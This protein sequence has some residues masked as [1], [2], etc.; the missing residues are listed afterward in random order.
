MLYRLIILNGERRGERITATQAP[1]TIGRGEACEIRFS[2]PEIA[3]AHAELTHRSEGL[4]IRDLDSMNRLLVNNREMREAHLK[5][6]D[7]VE[8]G[9]TR[10][11]VQAYVQAEVQGDEAGTARRKPWLI[12]AAVV[13]A[14]AAAGALLSR[15][16]PSTPPARAPTSEGS[17]PAHV[18]S[19]NVTPAPVTP[20]VAPAVTPAPTSAPVAAEAP[21][22][23]T[24]TPRRKKA[25]RPTEAPAAP[26]LKDAAEVMG[27]PDTNATPAV[28]AAAEKEL[29]EAA[30]ALLQ[31][32]VNEML[33]EA[34][35]V[36]ASNGPAAAEPLL[37]SIEK[38]SPSTVEASLLRAQV[39]EDQGKLEPALALWNDLR[40]RS[41][42]TA[43]VARAEAARQRLERAR[44]ELVFPFVGRI[45][46]VETSLNKFPE[47]GQYSEM[48]LLTIRLVA[49]EFQKEIDTAAVQ[50]E[51]RFYDRD[52]ATGN[53]EPTRAQVPAAPLTLTGSWRA[54]EERGVQAS[55]V[56]PTGDATA[57][58][59]RQY[60]G[61]VVRVRYY[62]ALQDERL[63]PKDL[64]GDVELAV[65][66]N[67]PSTNAAPASPPPVT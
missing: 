20:A 32:K 67:A 58:R 48:R 60:H 42:D 5:H 56:V 9:H 24:E 22:P 14:V 13:A 29:A 43:T 40:Q 8:V 15:C 19:V 35:G 26:E 53:I 10:F 66:D 3:M 39:L 34:R 18:V 33:D 23:A 44:N 31:S 57:R 54:T 1:M 17:R 49:T 2:D 51:V 65:P 47:T 21:T 62:G 11:L 30:Q 37:A 28:I 16:A 63:Q 61:F 12:A 36:A 38:I 50:V 55:Y 7:V 64:P 59:D 6:G 41:Q 25:A 46:I 27:T 4:H 45:K 52:P